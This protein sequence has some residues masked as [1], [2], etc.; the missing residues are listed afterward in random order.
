V[1]AWLWVFVG[2][3]RAGEFDW[4][5]WRGPQHNGVSTLKNLPDQWDP[6]GG[7]GSNLLWK[8]EDLGTKSTP[9]VMNGKLYTLCRHGARTKQDSEKVVCLDTKTGETLWENRFNVYLSDVPAERVGWS[10]V[11]GDPETGDVFALGVCGLF[12]CIDGET[13]ETK[14][15]HSLHEEYGLLSTY[16]GRTNFPV[17]HEDNVIVSAVL[18]NWGEHAKPRHQF[19]AFDKRNG[20]PVWMNGTRV[21]PEDTTYSSPVLGVINGQAAVVCGSG[22]G[23]LHAF[24][25]RTGK[26]LWTYNVSNHGLNVTPV[27]AEGR[28]YCGHGEENLDDTKMGAVFGVDGSLTGD[29]TKSGEVWRVKE[30]VVGRSTPLFVEGKLYVIDDRA[31]LH[32]LDADTGEEL[33]LQPLGSVQRSSPL[34]A[35]GKIY[36]ITENGV[37]YTLRPEGNGVE[38]VHKQRLSGESHASPIAAEGKLYV[39]LL[40]GIFCIGTA[41]AQPTGDPVPPPSGEIDIAQ[42]QEPA[43]VQVVPVEALLHPGEQ[44]PFHVRLYNAHGQWLRNADASEVQFSVD[45]PGTV[46]AEG[47]YSIPNTHTEHSGLIVTAKVGDV[48]GQARIRVVPGLDW[49]FNFDNGAVPLTWVGMRYRNI[50]IDYDLLTKLTEADPLA[51]QLYIYL[52]TDFTNFARAKSTFDDT[53]PAQGWTTFLRFLGLDETDLKPKTVDEAREKL[54]PS[55]DRLMDEGVLSS[56][57][58]S[59]WERNLSD[60]SKATETR[61]TVTKGERQIDGNG[62]MLKITT[63][64]KGTRS[65]GWMGHVGLHDYTVQAD[66]LAS[67]KDNTLPDLGLIGQRYTLA[68]MGQSQQLQ[69]RTWPPQLRMAVTVPFAWKAETWYTMK[70]QTAVEGGKA[71]LRGKAWPRGEEE[72]ADWQ[73]VA[74]DEP[75]E[76]QG[77]PGVYGDTKVSEAYFDNLTVRAN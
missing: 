43:V 16:G 33:G 23:G 30:L 46:S 68:L 25:P 2:A 77:S 32:I 34:Y 14:W 31:K 20:Q 75:G 15:Q 51:G 49:E 39:T 12:L 38:V 40:S 3:A 8:R 70:F 36:A 18:I 10:S 21:L 22:D 65:Q 67:L 74:E 45:G 55:L 41:D 37:W 73:L 47:T 9:I 17:I 27:I 35:D 11:V 57:D 61:L 48:T 42:D 58:W 24:Q 72:P 52:M 7:E 63:I 28:V 64:P 69:I 1:A 56:V 59:S 60:G 4:P 26:L 29:I 54:Q 5:Y 6:E 50:A 53:T 66:V 44:Q 71:V 76:H 19:L 13:G 62:V